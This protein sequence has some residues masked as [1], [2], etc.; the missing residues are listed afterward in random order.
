MEVRH[1]RPAVRIAFADL[2]PPLDGPCP[3]GAGPRAVG[4][5]L[6]RAP[7]GVVHEAGC[8][9]PVEGDPAHP[10]P[11]RAAR[12]PGPGVEEGA[13][14]IHPDLG[15]GIDL[16]RKRGRARIPDLF[17]DD[18]DS[19][20][21]LPLLLVAGPKALITGRGDPRGSVKGGPRGFVASSDSGYS[22]RSG[23]EAG[24]MDGGSDPMRQLFGLQPRLGWSRMKS[25]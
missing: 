20:A 4:R 9:A 17:R 15:G 7:R 1:E 11:R 3:L 18:R 19:G 2:D 21:P 16:L 10:H 12:G 5:L 8:M 22:R 23:F 24:R 13:G 25:G 6:P 14:R